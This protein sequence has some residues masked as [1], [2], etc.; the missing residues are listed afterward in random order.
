MLCAELPP[1]NPGMKD[2]MPPVSFWNRVT[3]TISKTARA[4]SVGMLSKVS[5]RHVRVTVRTCLL[6]SLV[7]AGPRALGLRRRAG[8]V[9]LDPLH[10]EYSF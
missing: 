3:T 4:A 6:G 7:A 10:L 8:L 1:P 9:L 5:V 2:K